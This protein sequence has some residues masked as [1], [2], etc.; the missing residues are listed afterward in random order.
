MT[1]TSLQKVLLVILER[2]GCA[3]WFLQIG[4]EPELI[5]PPQLQ[6]PSRSHPTWSGAATSLHRQLMLVHSG[7]GTI[8]DPGIL[9]LQQVQAGLV[10]LGFMQ[11]GLG[12]QSI[13]DFR[14]PLLL[15]EF[16][17]RCL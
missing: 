5:G 3:K 7:D 1:T 14:V 15:F 13:F 9:F 17:L 16:L 2:V 12:R 11:L 6:Q 4:T 8:F 10:Q